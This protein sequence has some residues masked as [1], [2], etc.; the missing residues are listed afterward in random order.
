M[1]E[2]SMVKSATL[3]AALGVAGAITLWSQM[4]AVNGTAGAAT[5]SPREL[6]ALAHL[7]GLPLEHFEDYSLVFS[8]VAKK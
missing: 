2:V 8:T 3:L 6:H 5:I 7:E 1:R 4:A